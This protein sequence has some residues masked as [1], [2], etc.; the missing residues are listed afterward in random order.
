[1]SH[2]PNLKRVVHLKYM[3]VPKGGSSLKQSA[4]ARRVWGAQGKDKKTIAL[5]VGYSPYSANS[6]M[7]KIESKP[8]FH[9]AMARL[10][11]DS[12]NLAFQVMSEFKSRGVKEFS[13]KD[14]ISAL[15]A[16][17]GA[18]DRFNKGLVQSEKPTDD[19]GKNRLR[20]V[21][22]QNISK[23]VNIAP[24]GESANAQEEKIKNEDNDF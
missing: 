7:S 14:L 15:N 13:D 9:N 12:G 10:A 21:V 23:Q 11:A 24:A 22:L 19:D 2:V 1:M 4:Y 6:V 3:K 5:D 18:W 16:I 17:S 8:G 20:T